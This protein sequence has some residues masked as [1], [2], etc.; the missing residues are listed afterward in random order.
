MHMVPSHNCN[1]EKILGVLVDKHLSKSQ[2]CG[3]AATKAIAVPDC[4]NRGLVSI[5]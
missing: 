4:I 3:A 1:C 2:Q 5:M